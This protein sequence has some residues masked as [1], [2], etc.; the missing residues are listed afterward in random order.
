MKAAE[1][2]SR[3][4]SQMKQ[5][6]IKNLVTDNNFN[7]SKSVI[8]VHI[9]HAD[10]S[11]EQDIYKIIDTPFQLLACCGLTVSNR[12]VIVIFDFRVQINNPR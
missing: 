9:V 5:R 4:K 10:Q 12:R 7:N 3:L 1:V 11:I 6:D 2:R 8:R